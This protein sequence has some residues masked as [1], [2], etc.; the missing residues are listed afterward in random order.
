MKL[1]AILSLL[2]LATALPINMEFRSLP[3]QKTFIPVADYPFQVTDGIPQ[4]TTSQTNSPVVT[5]IVRSAETGFTN[6][7]AV[8][9]NLATVV[10]FGLALIV[11]L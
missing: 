4:T 11:S 7:A 8:T 6:A 9:T 3:T 1:T 2:T 10:F 5:P